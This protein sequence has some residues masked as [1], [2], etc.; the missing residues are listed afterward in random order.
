MTKTL[1][2]PKRRG[3]RLSEIHKL[4]VLTHAA[5]DSLELCSKAGAGFDRDAF[6][7]VRRK[8]G[9]SQ[10]TVSLAGALACTDLDILRTMGANRFKHLKKADRLSLPHARSRKEHVHEAALTDVEDMLLA[11]PFECLRL[12]ALEALS[13]GG[14]PTEMVS[15]VDPPTWEHGGRPT[16][17]ERARQE[18]QARR[19]ELL[20]EE[21]CQVTEDDTG[22][23]RND[24][25]RLIAHLRD[26]AAHEFAKIGL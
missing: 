22:F 23:G 9:A 15:Y 19:I 1:T 21:F 18:H 5:A 11:T 24:T 12:E 4:G 17:Q 14:N 20:P 3:P 16:I 2:I 7:T 26:N 8:D 6:V 13:L 25:K 10:L